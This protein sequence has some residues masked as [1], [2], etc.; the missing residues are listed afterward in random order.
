M[1]LR[2][3]RMKRRIAVNLTP[4]AFLIVCP[5]LFLAGFVDAVGG[6]GGLISLP[7]YL[8][9]GLPIHN[10]IATNKLS[11][12]CGTSLATVRFIRKRMVNL[13]L[14][15]P[16]IIF[17][18]LGSSA[19]ANLSLHTSEKVMKYVLFAVLPA[20]AFCVLNRHLF[21]DGG[22]EEKEPDKRT[23]FAACV[24]ALI[25]GVYDGFY[26]PGT[27]TFLIIALTVFAKLG[28]VRANAQTKVINLTTNITSLVIFLRSGQVI[29]ALGLAGAVFNMLGN[30]A[31]SGLV[32]SKG[33]KIA[34]PM[35]LFVLAL[36]LVKTAVEM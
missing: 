27:G 31:G 36:L 32:M 6:G 7:A 28:I 21:P 18:M 11:S 3:F 17:A 12:A 9:A 20:A 24:S 22:E 14:A 25:V 2:F 34:R 16:T 23:Y 5:M 19:G 4:A 10:A 29:F 15:V 35:I 30:Y 26:G 13:R 1:S 8:F 33:S